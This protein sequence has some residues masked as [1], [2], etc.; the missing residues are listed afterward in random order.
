MQRPGD[1]L[2]ALLAIAVAAGAG[3]VLLTPPPAIF[4]GAG[5]TI[6]SALLLGWH[7]AVLVSHRRPDAVV[8]ARPPWIV[9]ASNVLLLAVCALPLAVPIPR[10][11]IG[12]LF[13]PVFLFGLMYL[14]YLPT[15]LLFWVA[16]GAGLRQQA[17]V[18]AKSFAW[19]DID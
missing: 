18:F 2:L 12:F 17:L 10:D 5:Y 9:L 11:G 19:P 14:G 1:T 16:D 6:L 8:L 7:A 13:L 15:T 4:I 3:A